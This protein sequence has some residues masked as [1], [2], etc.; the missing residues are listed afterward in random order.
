MLLPTCPVTIPAR[1]ALAFRGD[2]EIS[3]SEEESCTRRRLPP[4]SKTLA[5]DVIVMSLL[6]HHESYPV[7]T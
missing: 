3:R 7:L 5:G 4:P 2:V 6:A 1:G